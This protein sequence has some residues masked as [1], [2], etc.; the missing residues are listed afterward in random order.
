M[1][2][3][4]GLVF[5]GRTAN[6]EMKDWIVTISL[7]LLDLDWRPGIQTTE[8]FMVASLGLISFSWRELDL[9]IRANSSLIFSNGF[10]A[11]SGSSKR[12]GE[13]KLSKISLKRERKVF[14]NFDSKGVSGCLEIVSRKFE[15]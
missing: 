6:E 7:D 8:D 3:F 4:L 9:K 15:S 13:M 12:V 11:S 2:S 1:M 10:Q 14:W 5:V